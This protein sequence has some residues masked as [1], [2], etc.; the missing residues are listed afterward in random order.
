MAGFML[1]QRFRLVLRAPRL[2]RSV[3]Q[4]VFGLALCGASLTACKKKP[5][6]GPAPAP[7]A[8]ETSETATSAP[9]AVSSRPPSPGPVPTR[10]RE[11]PQSSPFRIG[12]VVASRVTRDDA[13]D[14]GPDEDDEVPD[15]YAVELGPARAD[16][17]GFTVSAL[18]SMKGG[19]HALV[20]FLGPDAASGKVVDLGVVHGDPDPPLFVAHGKDLLLAVPDTDAGGGMLKLGLLKDVRGAAQLSWGPEISG[21]R[22]DS[23]F[24]LELVGERAFL[25][26]AA[27]SGGKIR[28]F[29][30]SFDPSNP[31]QKLTPEP[32]S[33][34]GSD[35]DSPRLAVRKGGYWL[36]VLRALDAPKPKQKTPAGDAGSD[37]ADDSLLDIGTARIEVTKLDAQGKSASSPLIITAPGTRPMSLDLV[38]AADGGAYVGFRGDDSTPG[39]EGGALQL[40]H[41]KPDGSFESVHVE[42]EL[43]GTGTPSLLLDASDASQ[44]WLSAAGENGGT[45]FGRIN[46]HSTLAPDGLV[47][48]GD[49]IA[50]RDGHLLL[51]RTKGTAADFSVVHCAD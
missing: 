18:R 47:R 3:T 4:C 15:P 43:N 27:D 42:G 8:E 17:D 35:V 30:A 37:L 5:L 38:P 48:G 46:E 51:A 13:E 6:P 21:V 32:L 36:A 10:C 45:W 2:A 29:G 34:L 12:D 39:A 25:V 40:V 26:Y 7:E 50:V 24:A 19:S 41:V 49:L 20:A 44:L 22:S 11:L 1:K 16:A 23:T 33:A 28:V 14:G 31:K 9:P